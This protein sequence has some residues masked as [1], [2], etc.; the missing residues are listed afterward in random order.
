MRKIAG[1]VSAVALVTVTVLTF[2]KALL[3]TQAV[4]MG[5]DAGM[6]EESAAAKVAYRFPANAELFREFIAPV[7]AAEWAARAP[8]AAAACGS[9]FSPAMTIDCLSPKPAKATVAAVVE[10]PAAPAVE[11][12]PAPV[13][14]PLVP[15]PAAAAPVIADPA[16]PA[17]APAPKAALAPA[18]VAAAPV[19]QVRTR[20]TALAT[21]ASAA[22]VAAAAPVRAPVTVAPPSCAQTLPS[23]NARV[24]RVLARI[25]D[26]RTRQGSDACAAYRSDFFEI[27]Q[28]REVAALC[29]NGADRER[30]LRRIDG[31]VED[32]NGAIAQICGT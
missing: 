6:N 20:V 21:P 14:A 24:E 28:A 23:A 5:V 7:S 32:I 17:A 4:G 15:A 8:V 30:D 29:R 9:L 31:A 16:V 22:P 18:P 13:T 10:R 2:S 19:E 3:V 26:A 27:V 1:A 25:K 12:R 11:P